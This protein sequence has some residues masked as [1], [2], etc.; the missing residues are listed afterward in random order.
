MPLNNCIGFIDGSNQYCDK[1]GKYQSILFNGHKRAH[2]L[3]WQGIM[4]PNGIMPMPFG[5]V[6]GRHNDAFM[7]ERSEVIPAMRRACRRARKTYQ[8][9][10]DPAYP[11]SAWLSSPFPTHV[12]PTAAEARFNRR[13]S[14]ARIAVEWGF[15]K[16]KTNWAYLDFKKGMKPYQSDLQKFWPVAQILTN[17]H[18]CIYGNQT[19]NIVL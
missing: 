17:C 19:S 9:Y 15:G 13:M 7:L 1:P 2:C 8:L 18:T 6:N 14:S 11:Q 3:K 16:I 10:G 12:L 4:L 5:P